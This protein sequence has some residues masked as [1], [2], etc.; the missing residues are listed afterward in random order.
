M[1]PGITPRTP[2]APLPSARASL[3]P[4]LAAGTGPGGPTASCVLEAEAELDADLVVGD[5]AVDDLA[6]DLGHLEPVQ[7][8]QGLR[9]ALQR[10][11]DR[12]LDPLRRGAHD[13]G[14]AIRT[15]GHSSSILDDR[16]ARRRRAAPPRS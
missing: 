11:S 13:L 7:V 4:A 5:P 2:G 8:P 9:G 3:R 6:P 15:V 16:D 12:R 1:T 10:A 14:N